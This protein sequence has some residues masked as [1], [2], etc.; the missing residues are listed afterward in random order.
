MTR[1]Q[2]I[3]SLLAAGVACAAFGQ[4]GSQL[5]EPPPAP[6]S[7]W[8]QD[9]EAL[10]QAVR[11][12]ALSASEPRDLWV[13]GQLETSDPWA[14][15]GALAQA[16]TRVPGDKLY[17]GSLAM[18]CL[19]P[20]QPLAPECDATDRLADWATRDDDNGVQALLLANRA[21]QRNN[22]AAMVAFL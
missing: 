6:P 16:R 2:W 9:K 7:R 15:V 3:A 5:T 20:M 12:R 19:V 17:L 22:A 14:R 11:A 10:D 21:R 4:T 8:Q 18:A 1:A 13:S